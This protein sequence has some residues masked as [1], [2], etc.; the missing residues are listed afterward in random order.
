MPVMLMPKRLEGL[1]RYGGLAVQMALPIAIG[2]WLGSRM[3]H[4]QGSAKPYWTLLGLLLG[5]VM[6]FAGVW[7]RLKD[8]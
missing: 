3:D 6:A 8:R 7:S 4:R 5:L 2:A 1:A